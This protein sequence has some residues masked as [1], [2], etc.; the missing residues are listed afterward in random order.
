MQKLSAFILLAFA[1]T[2]MAITGCTTRYQIDDASVASQ[3]P[4]VKLERGQTVY[5]AMPQDGMYGETIYNGSGRQAAFALQ[6]ALLPYAASVVV[7]ENYE[8]QAVVLES[9]KSKNARYVFTT[10]ITNWVH[11]KAAWSGRASGVSMTVAVFDL[12]LESDKQRVI[13][14][15]LR[16]QGRNVTLV[17]QYPGEILKPLCAKFVQE[18][19]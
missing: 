5:I 10:V 18:I 16:V 7:G 9:A 2:L 6:T 12:S 11:R 14:K 8:D 1:A 3:M 4:G 13:Q 19:Y 17:S 15:D